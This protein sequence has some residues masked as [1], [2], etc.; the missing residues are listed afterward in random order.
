[1]RSTGGLGLPGGEA[2]SAA[3]PQS[4][5]TL[6]GRAPT[7]AVR[8]RPVQLMRKPTILLAFSAC[9]VFTFAYAGTQDRSATGNSY[10]LYTGAFKPSDA[11]VVKVP[12]RF[13]WSVETSW[14]GTDI[15]GN[16]LP[17][18]R[19]MVRLYDPDH[20]LTA[21]TAQLD[22]ETAER[23]QRELADIIAKKRQNP[24]FQHRP[25]LYDSSLIPTGRFKGI[26][27][28]GEAIIELEPKQAK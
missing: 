5:L 17:D 21:L 11:G 7:H 27:D 18:T 15:Q 6:F 8:R 13:K 14:R 12:S 10:H 20:N 9:A 19:V 2:C 28:N 25:K 4:S 24:D 1:M 26:T 23:L 22:L 3:R 16:N